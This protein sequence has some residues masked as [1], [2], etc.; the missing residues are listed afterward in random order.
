MRIFRNKPKCDDTNYIDSIFESWKIE[1][2]PRGIVD[3]NE[4][5][6]VEFDPILINRINFFAKCL[7]VQFK[8][9]EIEETNEFEYGI[10]KVYKF[11]SV[12]DNN[13]FRYYNISLTPFATTNTEI[14]SCELLLL[15]VGLKL[16]NE[17][18][19]RNKSWLIPEDITSNPI[20]YRQLLSITSIYFGFGTFLLRRNWIDS[21]YRF[22][23]E[24]GA[25]SIKYYVPIN[26]DY[27]TY[28]TALYCFEL[29]ED[30]ERVTEAIK[31]MAG[32]IKKEFKNCL[33]YLL[34]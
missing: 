7:G 34:G 25:F 4:L 27:L 16:N 20:H 23:D 30:K 13:G 18:E 5:E 28:A 19:S 12:E 15:L 2:I 26:V 21:R 24:S 9:S 32:E 14:A 11:E 10:P 33:N 1:D 29:P 6:K 8:Y 3:L 17:L 22:N 31:N